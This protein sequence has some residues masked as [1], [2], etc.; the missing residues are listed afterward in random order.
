MSEIPAYVE[1]LCKQLIA[2]LKYASS[3]DLE[4]VRKFLI[5][6]AKATID[7]E[8]HKRMREP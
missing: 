4:A 2:T 7:L 3:D 1:N 8:I 6:S 5:E